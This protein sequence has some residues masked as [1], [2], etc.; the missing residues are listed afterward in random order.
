MDNALPDLLYH[1]SLYHQTELKPGFKHTGKVV[2]WDKTESNM[3]LYVT[4]DKDTAIELGFASAIEKM[5]NVTHFRSVGNVISVET[6][7]PIT[8]KALAA[9]TVYLYTIR[10]LD[11]D[12]W[13]KNDN[14]NNGLTTEYKTDRTITVINSCV[15]VDLVDW[16]KTR[17]IEVRKPRQTKGVALEARTDKLYSW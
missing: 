8:L 6:D 12:G 4:S 7:Q 1:G 10:G 5:F 15:K 2:S 11:K 13:L 14:K 16:L 9:V 3:F 17:T